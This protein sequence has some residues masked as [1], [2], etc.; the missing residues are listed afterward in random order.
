MKRAM[1]MILVLA[2]SV[3]LAACGCK[4]EWQEATCTTPKT[5]KLC[6]ATE[7]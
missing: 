4:H 7:D 3:C 1:I 5:C 6:H 2:L